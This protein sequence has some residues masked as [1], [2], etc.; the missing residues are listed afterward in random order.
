VLQILATRG[1][2]RPSDIAVDLGVHQS[3]V[4]RQVRTLEAGGHVAVAG[5]PEDRRSCFITLTDAGW[6]EVARLTEVGLSRFAAFVA[7]WDAEDV[8]TLGRLLAKLE[9]SK[10]ELKAREQR[11]AGRNWQKPQ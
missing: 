11:P 2:V 3:T 4:T 7:D 9:R 1:R 10:S 8:R 5:D 6:G